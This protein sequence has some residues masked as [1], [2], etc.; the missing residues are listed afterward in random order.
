[1]DRYD[2]FGPSGVNSDEIIDR[3]E[4]VKVHSAIESTHVPL[5]ASVWQSLFSIKTGIDQQL[6]ISEVN[7]ALRE[8]EIKLWQS[9]GAVKLAARYQDEGLLET[10]QTRSAVTPRAILTEINQ[11]LDRVLAKLA[12]R[13]PDQALEI[14]QETYAYSFEAVEDEIKEKNPSLAR[15]LEVD[16]KIRLP[17]IISSDEGSR[18]AEMLFQT[19]KSKIDEARRLIKHAGEPQ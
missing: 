2:N 6:P 8:L 19:T 11:Q 16:F 3:W 15:E 14:L 9:L 13:L 7:A 18:Q 17:E 5:Y 10:V 12:E 1:M 4:T